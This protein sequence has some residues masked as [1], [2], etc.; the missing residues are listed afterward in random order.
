[1]EEGGSGGRF[2][3]WGPMNEIRRRERVR[4]LCHLTAAKRKGG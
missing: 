2:R 3:R 1:L 4:A